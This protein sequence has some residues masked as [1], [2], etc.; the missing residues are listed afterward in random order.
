MPRVRIGTRVSVDGLR[1]VVVGHRPQGMVDIQVDGQD[2]IARKRESSLQRSNPGKGSSPLR[3]RREV[4]KMLHNPP[5]SW[6]ALY[7]RAG[8]SARPSV[9]DF[10]DIVRSKTPSGRSAEAHYG[11]EMGQ[12]RHVPPKAVREAALH[13][14]RLSYN[15]NYTSQSGVGLARAV[16]LV[17]DPSIDDLAKTR[18]RAYLTRHERDK[19]GKNFG[20]DQNPSNGYMAWLNWGGDP[21]KEWLNMRNN[22][23]FGGGRKKALVK[24]AKR[25]APKESFQ[26]AIDLYN[27]SGAT[28]DEALVLA[29]NKKGTGHAWYWI[30]ARKGLGLRAFAN[31]TRS[32]IPQRYITDKDPTAAVIANLQDY[33]NGRDLTYVT[34][35]TFT[36]TV[37]GPF[38]GADILPAVANPARKKPEQMKKQ[39]DQFRAVVQGIYE[40]LMAK[41]LGV[42]SI[43]TP[44][45]QRRDVAALRMGT[46]SR[47][48]QQDTLGRAF[49]IATRQGQKHGYLIP[50]SQEPTE[51]GRRRAYKRQ[52]DAKAQAQNEQDYEVTL[53]LARKSGPLRIVAKGRGK[54][55]RFHVQPL[56]PGL[57]PKGYKTESAAKA[58]ITRLRRNPSHLEE[59]LGRGRLGSDD[60]T[61]T[62]SSL[63]AR[64][65]KR[66]TEL[67]EWSETA[68][69]TR[70]PNAHQ[71]FGPL[72][73]DL[74]EAERNRGLTPIQMRQAAA[75][76]LLAFAANVGGAKLD[77]A[78]EAIA[79]SISPELF[80]RAPK[81]TPEEKVRVRSV[82][83]ALEQREQAQRRGAFRS[84]PASPE[85]K[86]TALQN[87]FMETVLD[88]LGEA[89]PTS[90]AEGRAL[91]AKI[92]RLDPNAMTLLEDLNR[93]T[94]TMPK[95]QLQQ[96][97]DRTQAFT[98]FQKGRFMPDVVG[99]SD[100]GGWEFVAGVR[101]GK[102]E[103]DRRKAGKAKGK[104]KAGIGRAGVGIGDLS[105]K[106]R[107]AEDTTFT[108]P[109]GREGD[110]Y[111]VVIGKDD[112]GNPIEFSGNISYTIAK[113]SGNMT[114]HYGEGD[115][116]RF[117]PLGVPAALEDRIVSAS[118]V[119]EANEIMDLM[120]RSPLGLKQMYRDEMGRINIKPLTPEELQAALNRSPAINFRKLAKT[121]V[122]AG[123]S[124]RDR[125][126]WDRP[127]VAFT[128][129][130]TFDDRLGK[131]VEFETY[132]VYGFGG[133]PAR[134][135]SA[136][137]RVKT[138]RRQ[139]KPWKE[140]LGTYGA[141]MGTWNAR[142]AHKVFGARGKFFIVGPLVGQGM[143]QQGFKAYMKTLRT[144]ARMPAE[145]QK[146]W[147]PALR[148]E[149]PEVFYYKTKAEAE[150]VR[151]RLDKKLGKKRTQV[152]D[153]S[154][155]TYAF[156]IDPERA[157]EDGGYAVAVAAAEE[158]RA[159]PPTPPGGSVGAGRRAALRKSVK[160]GA[161]RRQLADIIEIVE[162]QFNDL[163]AR[164]LKAINAA[165][166]AGDADEVARLRAVAKSMRKLRARIQRAGQL[167]DERQ[168]EQSM[169]SI[170][171]AIESLEE[172]L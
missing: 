24:K 116:Y 99:Q 151:K 87:I 63:N 160:A 7:K 101:R 163:A 157:G 109:P 169:A 142:A 97:V 111:P 104:V 93:A 131:P 95:A 146:K 155:A 145:L 49:A 134:I 28:A 1:G 70:L 41:R 108:A 59:T 83:S 84:L 170:Y 149:T 10:I 57:N 164:G 54:S 45:G 52:E 5:S 125:E 14:L 51:K 88:I 135:Q 98:E 20:N 12:G 16:Q 76:R 138:K 171:T 162:D 27:A 167:T 154:G 156:Y 72:M 100:V 137:N 147:A 6:K 124:R 74:V 50:G 60:D 23:I 29:M 89:P 67:A 80:R 65:R 73:N 17:L 115:T 112:N 119:D 130:K 110:D 128:K 152:S 56:M 107:V 113:S 42:K 123:Y 117:L 118:S 159:V 136:L 139:W 79:R 168:M 30:P 144:F 36:G 69:A 39:D 126:Q 31:A 46:L 3:V 13:G 21:A 75:E 78:A 44:T 47:E 66:L 165:A 61:L 19:Q 86:I 40:S 85:A 22:P 55:R 15:S 96:L 68:S 120:G 43:Y 48:E 82:Q 121:I 4:E 26:R 92:R 106:G 105:R 133:N 150:T 127:M 91:R 161:T 172:Q 64:I 148:A 77:Q 140:A 8:L 9:D 114:L 166:K 141:P 38:K 35:D 143:T 71:F 94:P 58:A 25:I 103:A 81:M 102:E 33:H 18:M 53:S 132:V 11:R 37:T 32:S 90:R 2:F 122:D 62:D 34:I 158:L 153:T 129:V